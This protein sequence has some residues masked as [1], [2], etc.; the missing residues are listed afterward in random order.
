MGFDEEFCAKNM[1]SVEA[2]LF[3]EYSLKVIMDAFHLADDGSDIP[4]HKTTNNC[5]VF[6]INMGKNLGIDIRS[7]PTLGAYIARHV[8]DANGPNTIVHGRALKR[9]VVGVGECVGF[10]GNSIGACIGGTTI[11]SFVGGFVGG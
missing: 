2:Y 4:Y 10:F 8:N 9:G 5:S 3:G 7:R 1:A 11:G 6:L